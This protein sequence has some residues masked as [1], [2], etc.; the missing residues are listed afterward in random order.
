MCSSQ[1]GR[2]RNIIEHWSGLCQRGGTEKTFI[3][4]TIWRSDRGGK[5]RFTDIKGMFGRGRE[6]MK[7]EHDAHL[8]RV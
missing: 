3:L 1:R 8:R 2:G 7:K 4:R 5:E 6:R